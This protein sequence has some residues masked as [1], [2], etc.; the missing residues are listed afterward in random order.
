MAL[1]PEETAI[2]AYHIL[3]FYYSQGELSVGG[4]AINAFAGM[5]RFLSDRLH[6]SILEGLLTSS[7]D[8][9]ILYYGSGLKRRSEFPS[10]SWAGWSGAVDWPQWN[11]DPEF[12]SA[13]S[14]SATE[15]LDTRTW[16]VWSAMTPD[17]ALQPL[18]IGLETAAAADEKY[19][20]YRNRCHPLLTRGNVPNP[21]MQQTA[22][23]TR[24]YTLLRFSSTSIRLLVSSSL[25]RGIRRLPIVD[26]FLL[27]DRRGDTCGYVIPNNAKLVR[28]GKE[29][30]VILLSECTESLWLSVQEDAHLEASGDYPFYWVMVVAWD[31]DIA[32][33]RGIGIVREG[34]ERWSY[35]SGPVW[36]EILLG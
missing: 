20:G 1:D 12:Q 36:K 10:Y 6:T 11:F 33:R 32:E 13:E 19:V 24:Q 18:D 21:G 16:I 17:E 34:A 2:D 14:I 25:E 15:W 3:L 30:E 22:N 23:K 29:V 27:A 31:G 5:L 8:I 28:I 26:T 7:F 4:D 9:S 35:S